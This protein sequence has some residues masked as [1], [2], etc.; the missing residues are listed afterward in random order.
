MVIN[1]YHLISSE[2]EP[3]GVDVGEGVTLGTESYVGG[4][5]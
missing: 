2:D 1:N 5:F 3:G 4:W